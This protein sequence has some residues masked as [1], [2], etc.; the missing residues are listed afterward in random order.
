MKFLSRII[1]LYMVSITLM[2]VTPALATD[3][4]NIDLNADFVSRY[5]WRGT[6]MNDGPNVQPSI[7]LGMKGFELGIW[8][9]STLT[10]N[11]SSDEYYPISQEVDFWF[12]YKHAFESGAGIGLILTDYYFPK[13]GIRQGNYNNHDHADGPG[14]HTLEAGV[15]FTGPTSFPVSV[16]YFRNIYNDVGNNSYFQLDY[17]TKAKEIGLD[18]FIGAAMG[19][20]DNP[21]YYGTDGFNVINFGITAN[22]SMKITDSFSLPVFVTYVVNPRIENGY[23][24]FGFS[25]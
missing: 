11:N 22:K 14:A 19:S 4:V 2:A 8:G 21:G 16:S 18:F 9:S 20:E 24:I 5:I 15:I 17:S 13:A 7:T 3:G 25:L 23:L 1:F 10:N 12:G 6:V